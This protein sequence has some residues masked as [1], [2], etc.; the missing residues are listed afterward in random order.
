M[1]S[2]A[3]LSAAIHTSFEPVTGTWQYVVADPSTHD[4]AIID[5]VLD[6]DPVSSRINTKSADILLSIVAQE[7]LQVKYIMETHAHADHLTAARYLQQKLIQ[8]G[9][10]RPQIAIGKRITQVQR[11]F[12]GKYGV[13]KEEQ[14]EM[15]DKLWEDRKSVV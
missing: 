5:S 10:P 11:T 1:P 4:A 6:F 7:K 9:H 12:A 8:L 2:K 13:A 3:H 15:F 14:V